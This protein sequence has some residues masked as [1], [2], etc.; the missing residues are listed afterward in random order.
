MFRNDYFHHHVKGHRKH[1]KI[2]EKFYVSDSE[3]QQNDEKINTESSLDP[4]SSSCSSPDITSK[5]N[6]QQSYKDE[7]QVFY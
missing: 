5:L 3:N 4:S 2:E 7:V 1:A 6:I